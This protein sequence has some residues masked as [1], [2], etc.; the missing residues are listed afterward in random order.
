MF[1]LCGEVC[2]L[3]SAP[4]SS[5]SGCILAGLG[6]L[7]KEVKAIFNIMIIIRVILKRKLFLT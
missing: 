1:S 2:L 6:F 7:R 4:F 3:I 5:G